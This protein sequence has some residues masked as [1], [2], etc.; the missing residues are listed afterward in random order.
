MESTHSSVGDEHCSKLALPTI[1]PEMFEALGGEEDG[2][3]GSDVAGFS[4]C[5][6][7]SATGRQRQELSRPKLCDL[8]RLYL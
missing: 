3:L 4:C 2:V 8:C 7:D 5:A 1:T 6:G